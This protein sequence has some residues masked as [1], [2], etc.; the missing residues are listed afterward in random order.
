MDSLEII[1][2]RIY[3]LRTNAGETQDEAAEAIG[4]SHVAL[5]RYENGQRMP[6]L[7]ILTSIAQHY[8]ISVDN[9]IGNDNNKTPQTDDDLW[10]L[11]EQLRRDP[12]RQILF[13]LARDADISEVRQ[14]V[15]II[16]A[17]KK[18]SGR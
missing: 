1:G 17:L 14:A 16:D 3:A 2:K 11:R 18:T 8:G 6:K 4:I 7:N 12:E 9:L 5:A 13:S 10:N 15:A